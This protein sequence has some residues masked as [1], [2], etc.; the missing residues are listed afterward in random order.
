MVTIRHKFTHSYGDDKTSIN[1]QLFVIAIT[2][3]GQQ[4]RQAC[5]QESVQW[6]VHLRVD[7]EG[8]GGEHCSL[9]QLRGPAHGKH[10]KKHEFEYE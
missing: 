3:L 10:T 8:G 1:P 6:C 5:C 9:P 2:H 4:V 7:G